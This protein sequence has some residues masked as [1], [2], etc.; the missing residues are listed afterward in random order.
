MSASDVKKIVWPVHSVDN[1]ATWASKVALIEAFCKLTNVEVIGWVGGPVH[2][3]TYRKVP[4]RYRFS[5]SGSGASVVLYFAPNWEHIYIGSKFPAMPLSIEEMI[6]LIE[7]G[8]RDG[9]AVKECPINADSHG[10]TSE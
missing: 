4:V 2:E 10:E 9:T 8:L 1:N 5:P 7:K 6:T 3:H